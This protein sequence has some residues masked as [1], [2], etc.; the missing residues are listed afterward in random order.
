M[1]R[2]IADTGLVLPWNGVMPGKVIAMET[3]IG[4]VLAADVELDVSAFCAARGISRQTFYKY[5]ARFRL[6][7]WPV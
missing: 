2:D 1:S 7:G 5:R 6:R 3:L 4:A